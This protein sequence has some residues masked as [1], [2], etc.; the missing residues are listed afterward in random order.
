MYG[1]EDYKALYAPT[2]KALTLKPGGYGP[3]DSQK[4][5]SMPVKANTFRSMLAYFNVE[6]E[7]KMTKL[8]RNKLGQVFRKSRSISR[9]QR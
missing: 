3:H 4:A 7:L 8:S 2:A 6:C 5:P 1:L 9:Q